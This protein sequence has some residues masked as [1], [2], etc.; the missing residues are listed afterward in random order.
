MRFFACKMKRAN[1]YSRGCFYPEKLIFFESN[2][3]SNFGS[4]FESNFGSSPR[5]SPC[6]VLCRSG[7]RRALKVI[8]TWWVQNM[9]FIAVRNFKKFD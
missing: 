1:Q 8:L 6:F 9:C 5:S 3:G 2:F 7:V 4:N